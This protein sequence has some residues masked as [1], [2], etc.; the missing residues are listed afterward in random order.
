MFRSP[1][2]FLSLSLSFLS[3]FF[4]FIPTLFSIS[5]P[6]FGNANFQKLLWQTRNK[7]IEIKWRKSNILKF[8]ST[9]LILYFSSF[10]PLLF[11]SL[12]LFSLASSTLLIF[13]SLILF[14]SLSFTPFSFLCY[15][16]FYKVLNVCGSFIDSKFW[17]LVYF[18]YP[19]SF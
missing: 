16:L 12:I 18:F 1:T 11:L 9:L 19:S 4:L 17:P 15:P 13:L 8:T 3:F 2:P 5:L 7:K 10:L 14:S 6:F